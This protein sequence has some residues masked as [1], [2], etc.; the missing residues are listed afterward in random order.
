[1][2]LIIIMIENTLLTLYQVSKDAL[3]L[4]EKL[5]KRWEGYNQRARKVRE[6]HR[7]GHHRHQEQICPQVLGTCGTSGRATGTKTAKSAIAVS[8]ATTTSNVPYAKTF[9]CPTPSQ[10]MLSRSYY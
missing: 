8:K 2:S 7:Q 6:D 1:M 5:K 3:V 10:S 4:M 9:K